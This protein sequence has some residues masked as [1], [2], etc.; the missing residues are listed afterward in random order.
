MYCYY[1]ILAITKMNAN[2]SDSDTNSDDDLE[3]NTQSDPN[4]NTN[5]TNNTGN[6]DKK[7]K[8]KKKKNKAKNDD[9]TNSQSKPQSA[10]A[11]LILERKKLQEEEEARIKAIEEENKRI[12]EEEEKKRLDEIKK[13]EEEKERK[14]KA[15]QDKI[16]EKKKA[17][18][19][20]TKSEKERTKKNQLKLE[21]LKKLG[22]MK[23][24]G[25]IIYVQEKQPVQYVSEN[26]ND[27]DNNENLT[28]S[29]D[30]DEDEDD[31]DSTQTDERNNSNTKTE[32]NFKCPILTIFGHVDTGKTSLLDNL[33]MTSIQNREIGGITQKISATLLTLETLL[34]RTSYVN[35]TNHHD[36]KIPGLLLIDT[37]G[38]E[39]FGNLRENG[40]RLADIAI[41]IVDIT[42]GLEPQTIESI[43][44]LKKS[45]TP[46]VIGL[47][48]I[49]RLYG[50]EVKDDDECKSIVKILELQDAN[51]SSEFDTKYSRIRTQLMELGLN[52]ELGWKNTSE[53]DTL[54]VFPISATR[55]YGIADML[56]WII[57][58]SQQT[59]TNQ[60]T[61]NSDNFDCVLMEVSNVEGHGYAID[62]MLKNGILRKDSIIK[63]QTNSI[64]TPTILTKIKNILTITANKDSSYLTKYTSDDMVKG[65]CWIKI[66]AEGLEKAIPNTIITLETQE[67]FDNYLSGHTTKAQCEEN[68]N[69]IQLDKIGIGLFAETHGSLEALEKLIRSSNEYANP[70]PIP[71]S[72]V[73]VGTITKKD[74]VRLALVNKDNLSYQENLSVLGFEV[75][76]DDDAVKYAKD[77]KINIFQD[78][79]IYRLFTQFKD[80]ANKMYM[81]RKENARKLAVFPCILKIIESNVFNKKN[82][83]VMGVEIIEGVLHNGTPL[84]TYSNGSEPIYIGKVVG[85]QI[86]KKDVEVGR[87][88]NQVCIKIDND[89]NPTITYGRQFTHTDL[90]Y[91]KLTRNSVDVLKEY[92]KKDLSNDDVKLLMKLKKIIGF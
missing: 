35:V 9:K 41:V 72:Q 18:T 2:Q 14:K 52:N 80:Y 87:V 20:L 65:S 16:I 45:N 12:E 3:L 22:I 73:N 5:N 23:D 31:N 40:A 4:L 15:K 24:D 25:R 63:V 61:W 37:P 46:F 10:M 79:T 26:A 53:I 13:K 90:L 91:S 89:V 34:K 58:Y 88:G 6:K 64:A 78:Q 59:L 33:R 68:V 81:E 43:E 44:L 27:E 29:D 74:L 51:V 32:Y 76:I 77:N 66:C 48:K 1:K 56:D 92:F 82:P 11:K 39:V 8:N 42:H 57:K 71:I 36:Y 85:I 47:N 19:Y 21:Q 30:S 75:K 17:G 54:S 69:L 55:G 28:D 7:K 62:C 84:S 49:D 50:F 67:E 83:L 70:S 86:N 38:H 60:I